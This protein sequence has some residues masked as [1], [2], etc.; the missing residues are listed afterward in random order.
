MVYLYRV[1]NFI[2]GTVIENTKS[3]VLLNNGSYNFKTVCHE[4]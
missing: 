2:V 3:K 4:N 1:N